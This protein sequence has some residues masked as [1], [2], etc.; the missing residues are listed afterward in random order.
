[1]KDVWKTDPQ[2]LLNTLVEGSVTR[3]GEI[4]PDWVNFLKS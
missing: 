3:F 4:S 2:G 1:M